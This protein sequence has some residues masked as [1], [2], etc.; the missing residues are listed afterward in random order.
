MKI[1]FII[2]SR[3]KSERLPGKA[4]IDIDGHPLLMHIFLSVLKITDRK[5]IVVATSTHLFDQPIIDF[6]QKN[7]IQCYKG[8]MENVAHRF[9]M[10]AK[11]YSLDYAVRL[12]GDNVFID[13][14]YMAKMLEVARLN[15]YDFISNVK[16]RTFPKGMSI[17]IVRVGYYEKKYKGFTSRNHFEHVTTYLYQNDE[18]ENYY[19]EFNKEVIEAA[20]LQLAVDTFEDLVVARKIMRELNK[21]KQGVSLGNIFRIYKGLKNE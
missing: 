6:C 7:N 1:G 19:Y 16:G 12:N 14:T 5:N 11:E 4:L 13:D 21:R 3:Y 8:D 18:G 10:C 20:G 9:L 17:E 2:L 15:K